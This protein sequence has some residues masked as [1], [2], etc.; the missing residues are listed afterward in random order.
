MCGCLLFTK[1]RSFHAFFHTAVTAIRNEDIN[2]DNGR[3]AAE[4]LERLS[5]LFIGISHCGRRPHPHIRVVHIYGD[6]THNSC[7]LVHIQG[8]FTVIPF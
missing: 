8:S 5:Y 4:D 6:M 2:S 3:A 7:Q 1:Q